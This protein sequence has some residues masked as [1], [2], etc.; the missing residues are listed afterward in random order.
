MDW[1]PK[2]WQV[3]TLMDVYKQ[4]LLMWMNAREILDWFAKKYV[5]SASD[6]KEEK[7]QGK[8]LHCSSKFILLFKKFRDNRPMPVVQLSSGTFGV[9]F[10]L[11]CG[12]YTTAPMS[13]NTYV[14]PNI[15]MSYFKVT[16]NADN[17]IQ[18]VMKDDIMR[19]CIVLPELV[20]YGLT[21]A[22]HET[23]YTMI[24]WSWPIIDKDDGNMIMCKYNKLEND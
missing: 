21:I 14:H 18:N 6:K 16:L 11:D 17:L 15:G 12:K 4:A 24:D 19:Y 8:L 10:G 7:Y 2:K 1:I 22:G 13:F 5:G 20:R 23:I 3:N 9:M